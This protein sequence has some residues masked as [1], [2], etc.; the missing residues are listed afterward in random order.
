M[1]LKCGK[2]DF[3]TMPRQSGFDFLDAALPPDEVG[4]FT[5]NGYFLNAAKPIFPTRSF[6]AFATRRM[7]VAVQMTE[8]NP[9]GQS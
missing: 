7:T 6:V 5:E 3:R 2:A 9:F 8:T 4:L 1:F